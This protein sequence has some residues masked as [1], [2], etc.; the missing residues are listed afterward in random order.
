LVTGLAKVGNIEFGTFCIKVIVATVPEDRE[1][2]E[3]FEL[4]ELTLLWELLEESVLLLLELEDGLLKELGLLWE[5][6]DELL[7]LDE[8]DDEFELA[9]LIEET[10]DFDD[11]LLELE[12]LELT[13]LILLTELGDELEEELLD[14]E[15]G[16]LCDDLELDEL[17]ELELDEFEEGLLTELTLLL[18]DEL[19][20]LL[21]LFELCELLLLGLDAL[22]LDDDELFELGLPAPDT[23]LEELLDDALE[24]ELSVLAFKFANNKLAN[25]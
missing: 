6:F 22:L 14:G 19:E 11:E 16:L 23:E 9:E 2:S 13:L 18:D 1:E 4:T 21:E 17:L 15:L 3:L 24:S 8:L 7:E 5:L 20:L 12:E 10:L 25:S